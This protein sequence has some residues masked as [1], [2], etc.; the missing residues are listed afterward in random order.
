MNIPAH[1]A[2]IAGIQ[3]GSVFYF[4]EES[5][6]SI[7]PHYFVVLNR[8]P[9]TEEILILAIASSQVVKRRKI[10]ERLGFSKETLVEIAPEEYP[11]FTKKTVID[12]NR[13]FEKSIQSLAE[14]LENGKLKVCDEIMPSE[15]IKRILVGMLMSTQISKNIQNMLAK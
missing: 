8:N 10:V 13:A 6:S 7:E 2:L 3:T 1:I 14:K 11:L 5:I 4:E 15:I 9:K 12:C